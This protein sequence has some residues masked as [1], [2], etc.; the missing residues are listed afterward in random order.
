MYQ[1]THARTRTHTRIIF[2]D[3]AKFIVT[4]SPLDSRHFLPANSSSF[5]SIQI[6]HPLCTA[7]WCL[8][9]HHTAILPSS[10]LR[11][12]GSW[13]SIALGS[14]SKV[15]SG[16]VSASKSADVTASSQISI[17]TEYTYLSHSETD[18]SFITVNASANLSIHVSVLNY[19]TMFLTNLL[20]NS[21]SNDKGL[22]RY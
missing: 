6:T 15:T 12:Q 20:S 13:L 3:K 21:S 10:V 9:F 2:D 14:S 7:M 11:W 16:I 19:Y 1:N 17:T 8:P 4:C 5:P 18:S 22:R